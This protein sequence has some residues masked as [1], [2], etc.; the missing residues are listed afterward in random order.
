MQC[1]A[2]INAG[3]RNKVLLPIDQGYESQVKTWFDEASRLRPW[4]LVLPESTTELSSTLTA[5]LGA[6]KGAG[7]WHI[8]LRSGGHS[9]GAINNIVNGVTIDLSH[10]NATS[11]D[12][13]TNVAS[14][15]PGARWM[16]VYASL[17]KQGVT[18]VGGR[19]GGVG[20]GG[21]LLGGGTSFFSGTQGFGC[22]NVINYELVLADGSV[23]N[24]NASSH[25]DLWKALK[26]GGG[27]LGI[28]TR[29]DLEAISAAPIFHDIRFIHGNYSDMVVDT[30]VNFASHS[31]TEG[32]NA[33][34]SFW[35][36]DASVSPGSTVGTI[37]VNTDGD[38][39][40]GTSYEN[41]MKV[42]AIF[43][44]TKT[45]TMAE[46][47]AAGQGLEPG[48]RYISPVCLSCGIR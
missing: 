5:L 32:A 43:H 45:M 34:V 41:V 38:D 7:D 3:L 6:G 19:D 22:D 28:V 30:V 35:M 37:Y 42:P 46:A 17:D 15:E 21:F 14:I 27:N 20:V 24:A 31:D 9:V 11:Y 36:H 44:E 1:D 16:D 26:G 13:D 25:S 10:L 33:L 2:L 40:A 29:F 18:V 12:P 23:V 47:A 8:A 39:N 48:S 4:C